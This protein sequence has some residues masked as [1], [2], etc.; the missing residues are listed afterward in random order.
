M[1]GKINLG[2]RHEQPEMNAHGARSWGVM[3]F[4][5]GARLGKLRAAV[6]AKAL[7]RGR[8]VV[9]FPRLLFIFFYQSYIYFVRIP[10]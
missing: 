1:W 6:P 3:A 9:N 4:A 5:C 7:R 10:I 2:Q 8:F